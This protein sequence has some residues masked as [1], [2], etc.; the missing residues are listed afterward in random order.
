MTRF[1]AEAW[2]V[3]GGAAPKVF[4]TEF[5]RI[6][7]SI[8][9]ISISPPC[10]PASG[11]RG[12]A[13]PGAL[14][15]RLPAGFNRVRLS[16]RARAVENQCYTAIV[17]LVGKAAWSGSIDVNF[18]QAPSSPPAMRASPMTAWPPPGR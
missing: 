12:K 17:P 16:A 3:T 6:G 13:D 11:G 14:L 8:C 5:G 18:G 4:E 9:Y 2:G 15:H 1:E 7:V 10:P